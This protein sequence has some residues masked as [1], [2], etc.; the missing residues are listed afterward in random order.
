MLICRN[1]LR[2]GL[3]LPL[4]DYIVEGVIDLSDV[5]ENQIAPGKVGDKNLRYKSV[6]QIPWECYM[7]WSYLKRQGYHFLRQAGPGMI[8]RR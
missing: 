5:A 4:D 7:T 6:G 3:V 8:S 2:R 1:G